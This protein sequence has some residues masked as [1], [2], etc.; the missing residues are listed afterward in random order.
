MVQQRRQ[1]EKEYHRDRVPGTF[2]YAFSSA[3]QKGILGRRD[4]KTIK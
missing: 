1:I 2:A 3:A 4:S